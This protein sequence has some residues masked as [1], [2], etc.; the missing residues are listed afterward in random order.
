MAGDRAALE[1]LLAQRLVVC[2]GPGGV[3]KTTTAAALGMAAALRGRATA[4]ITADPSRRLKDA[5]GLADLRSDPHPVALGNGAGRF[6]ALAIDTK[7][8]FDR[9][10][11]RVAANP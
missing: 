11:E 1:A 7:R 2:V 3:G 6:E 9:L 10:I 4:V 5:L 8:T